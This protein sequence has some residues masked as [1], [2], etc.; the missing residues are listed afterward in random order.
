MTFLREGFPMDFQFL[1]FDHLYG[2]ELELQI[3]EKVP[4]DEVKGWV[5]AYKYQ[6]IWPGT[7]TVV[8]VID[9]R[10]GYQESLYYGGNIGYTVYEGYRGQHFA[11]KACRLL[12]QVAMAHRMNKLIITCNPENIPS[13]KTCEYVGAQLIEIVDLPPHNDMYQRGERQVCVYQWDF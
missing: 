12:K 10:I 4:A 1:N 7:Q 5:P 13:R 6:M 9:L 8:G 11:G 3:E 2:E